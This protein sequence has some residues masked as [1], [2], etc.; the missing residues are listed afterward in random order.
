MDKEELS[1]LL[2]TILK[3][4]GEHAKT[5]ALIVDYIN[6]TAEISKR[7]QEKVLTLETKVAELEKIKVDK[8]VK[9]FFN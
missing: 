8:I 7:L 5:L 6:T 2:E 1:T 9:D 3:T 4:Q